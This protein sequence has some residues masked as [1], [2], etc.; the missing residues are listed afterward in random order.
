M[1]FAHYI[2]LLLAVSFKR[3]LTICSRRWLQL[4][5]WHFNRGY[6][7]IVIICIG[8]RQVVRSL[9]GDVI[10]PSD[11]GKTIASSQ[12]ANKLRSYLHLRDGL[13]DGLPPVWLLSEYPCPRIPMTEVSHVHV[14][15]H[16]QGWT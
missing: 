7:S 1:P 9:L 14:H 16:F 12:S 2:Q 6:V 3:T 11:P 4:L 15:F 5:A 10:Q 13:R 8:A